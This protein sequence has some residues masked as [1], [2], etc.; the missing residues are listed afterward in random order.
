MWKEEVVDLLSDI[1]HF[2]GVLTEM[3]E[4]PAEVV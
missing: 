1:N 3:L 2:L 4:I